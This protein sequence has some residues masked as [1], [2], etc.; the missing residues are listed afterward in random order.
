MLD[1]QKN[2]TVL[3]TFSESMLQEQN[4][5]NISLAACRERRNFPVLPKIRHEVH[6]YLSDTL[7]KI[8]KDEN[9]ALVNDAMARIIVFSNYSNFECHVQK[10]QGNKCYS[11]N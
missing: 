5:K 2:K 6:A 8:H 4:V 10:T 9:F 11:S 1:L 3:L 7:V